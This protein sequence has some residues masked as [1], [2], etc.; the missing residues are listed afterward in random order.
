MRM[1]LVGWAMSLVLCAAVQAAEPG[2]M[3]RPMVLDTMVVTAKRA[4]EPMRTGDV[5]RETLPAMITTIQREA[6]EGKTENIAEVLEK[7]AGVQVRQSGGTGSFS[8]LSLRGCS[9][10]Q[11]LVFMDGILLNDASGGGVDL[12]TIALSD[13]AAI[14]IYR[15]T[16]PI[17]FGNA[18][19][20]GAVNI[21]TLR[22]EQGLKTSASAGYGSFGTRKLNG[23][24]NHKP[25][26]LDYL[27][28]ADDIV[29]D[30]DF[31]FLNDNG[32]A[33]NAGDDRQ[34]R[35]HN[36]QVE[37]ANFLA[38]VGYDGSDRFR[39]DLMNQYFEKDQGIPNW[40][41]SPLTRSCLDTRRNITTVKLTADDFTAAKLN[42]STRFF[43]Y[44]ERR[45]VRRPGRAHRPGSTVQH[46]YHHAFDRGAVCRM[47]GAMA[48]PDRY[49]RP[50]A[51]GL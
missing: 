15:G 21:R 32:T 48:A 14:D 50:G 46:L 29:S 44:L 47:A 26:R 24:I 23:F 1:L 9:G 33:W 49:R 11:V 18:S 2:G 41:N 17:H 4:S 28:S 20:G 37:Q 16:T 13:V 42:T 6:F 3:N 7:E 40:N 31:T 5:D 22:P 30:N 10:D 38:K 12:G 34:E 8:S 39:V 35:R 51:R 19:I 27:L 36:A 43:L 45:R 25:G